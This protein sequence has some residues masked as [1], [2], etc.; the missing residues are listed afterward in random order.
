MSTTLKSIR[1]L[2]DFW[3]LVWLR[4][5]AFR[6]LRLLIVRGRVWWFV[7]LRR[8]LRTFEPPDA[9]FGTVQ[10][11]L[12]GLRMVSDRAGRLIRSAALVEDIGLGRTLII[13]CRNEDDLFVARL[14]GFQNV[15]GVDLISYRPEVV[16]GDMHDLPFA[17]DTFDCVLAPYVVSY[18]ANIRLA[19][20]EIV[21]VCANE[22][23]IGISVEYAATQ[24]DSAT[25][26]SPLVLA[27]GSGA[28][29][30]SALLALLGAVVDNIVVNYDALKRRSHS[31]E[32]LIENVS[33]VDL[34]VTIRKP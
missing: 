21:R 34:V 3:D 27:D 19:I 18:S 25:F 12:Q 14:A 7:R 13:G 23:V 11:N 29:S 22:G 30:T 33:P 24:L 6:E 4:I 32:G 20:D 9:A 10:H 28:R 1:S 15:V 5:L 17:D 8:R 31:N 2:Q 26:G 16:L